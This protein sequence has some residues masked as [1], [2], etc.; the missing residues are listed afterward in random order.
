MNSLDLVEN[1]SGRDIILLLGHS[2][3]GKS[4]TINALRGVRF[5]WNKISQEEDDE[6]TEKLVPVS[7]PEGLV[8]APMGEGARCVTTK[9][10]AYEGISQ[11]RIVDTRG[12]GELGEDK[13]GEMA[14][15]ILLEMV[16]KAAHSIRIVVLASFSQLDQIQQ[17]R[18]VMEQ[19]GNLLPDPSSDICWVVNRHPDTRPGASPLTEATESKVMKTIRGTIA[20]RYKSL[21]SSKWSAEKR[22]LSTTEII[23]ERTMFA[24]YQ[25]RTD[26]MGYIDPISQWS[27]NKISR[28]ITEIAPINISKMKF[29]RENR[30]RVIFDCEFQQ[31]LQ[32]RTLL[33]TLYPKFKAIDS[34]SIT[35]ASAAS[36]ETADLNEKAARIAAL[37]KEMAKLRKDYQVTSEKEEVIY[38]GRFDVP[39][40]VLTNWWPSYTVI[41][42]HDLRHISVLYCRPN[43]MT[44]THVKS[45]Y[46]E[47]GW[48]VAWT[49]Y[50]GRTGIPGPVSQVVFESDRWCHCSGSLDFCAK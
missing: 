6:E 28:R 50:G 38:T 44:G 37:E 29:G 4:T 43:L 9:P 48:S 12:V 41:Y 13:A 47:D 7:I 30:H 21:N 42:P 27:I 49:S 40:R 45:V 23:Q 16:C 11:F 10:A 34:A 2:Q 35:G 5:A 33:L 15:S 24:I 3:V 20:K 36:E 32:S 8:L 26:R 14:A 22:E 18:F 31:L 39:W 46:P 19:I 17:L 25:A 1:V